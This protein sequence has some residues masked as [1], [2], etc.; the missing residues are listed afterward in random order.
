MI[1][2]EKS[3]IFVE[4]G[5]GT[6]SL[7]T[8][9]K[10]PMGVNPAKHSI[11]QIFQGDRSVFLAIWAYVSPKPFSELCYAVVFVKSV[12]HPIINIFHADHN[13]L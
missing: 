6:G 8:K 13:Q 1:P 12:S 11:P 10:V 9:I 5:S 3:S 2:V 4:G 7:D